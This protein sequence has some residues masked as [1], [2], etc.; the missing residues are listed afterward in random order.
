MKLFRLKT[1]FWGKDLNE[2]ASLGYIVAESEEEVAEYIN[3]KYCYGDWFG[4]NEDGDEDYVEMLRQDFIAHNGNFHTE[5]RGEFYD[6]KYGWEE[7]GDIKDDQLD[8]LK[9]FGIIVEKEP[10]TI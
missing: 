7:L 3:N 5:Y 6:Q 2:K 4:S 9:A 8:V 1:E 10:A